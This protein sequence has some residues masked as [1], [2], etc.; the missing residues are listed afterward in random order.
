M[1]GNL[2]EVKMNRKFVFSLFSLVLLLSLSLSACS[3]TVATLA[4]S[5]IVERTAEYVGE[6]SGTEFFVALAV[7]PSGDVLAYVCNG[8]GSE[9]LFRGIVRDD[10][11]NLTSED[12]KA[13]LE[14][15]FD[16][17]SYNGTF[18]VDGKE[19]S[20]TTVPAQDYGGLYR[21]TGL[22]EF[23]AEGTSQG[24]AAL[25]MNLTPDKERLQVTV[26]TPDGKT[27]SF[28]RAWP[29]GHHDHS[30]PTEYSESWLIFLNDSRAQGGH[31]QSS[32]KRGVR[33][34]DPI[35]PP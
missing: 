22:S 28:D 21:V 2:F 13:S 20:F 26:T 14:A 30:E 27:L 12:G 15:R 29:E 3:P 23:E 8:M 4:S 17:R 7:G 5:A 34:I 6:V 19:Y 24:G 18:S 32:L 31:I 35:C 11:V 25:K 16:D 9:Y 33:H 1:D 10:S